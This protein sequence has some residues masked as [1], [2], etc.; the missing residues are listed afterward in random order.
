MQAQLAEAKTA[1]V[2]TF[3]NLDYPPVAQSHASTLSRAEVQNELAQAKTAGLVTYGNLDYP[4]WAAD[5]TA[6]RRTFLTGPAQ[7]QRSP[8]AARRK[9]F[10]RFDV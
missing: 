2:V 3:G 6:A 9:G 7:A 8:S 4:P 10:C 5:P 1:G